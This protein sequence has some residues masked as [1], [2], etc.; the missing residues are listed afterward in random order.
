MPLSR[1]LAWKRRKNIFLC[2]Q[3]VVEWNFVILRC[4]MANLGFHWLFS[5]KSKNCCSSQSNF[6]LSRSVRKQSLWK[7][8]QLERWRL[9]PWSKKS[10]KTFWTTWTWT[11]TSFWKNGNFSTFLHNQVS[12]DKNENQQLFQKLWW[13][14]E[15]SAGPQCKKSS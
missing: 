12:N 6:D 4:L 3:G 10:S 2:N 11:S 8:P 9:R 7:T 13:N 14:E 1:S 5:R 15:A